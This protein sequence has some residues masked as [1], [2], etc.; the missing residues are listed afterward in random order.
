MYEKI[1]GPVILSVI[2]KTDGV[3][4]PSGIDV[5]EWKCLL[6]P[7]QKGTNLSDLCEAVAMLAR[8]ISSQCVDT[9]GLTLF[10]ACKLVALDKCSGVRPIGIGEVLRRIM[11]KAILVVHVI[12]PD[13]Q[14]VTGA[15]QVCTG[16]QGG[17]EAAKLQYMQ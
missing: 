13:V 17:C 15:L 11:G 3:A 16:Q 4:G 12:G 9:S 8:R 7:F 14:Q 2:L 5:A 10:T 1:D 6:S